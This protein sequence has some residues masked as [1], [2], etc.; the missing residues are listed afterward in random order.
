VRYG[1]SLLPI[2][3][4]LDELRGLLNAR[5]RGDD[6]FSRGAALVKAYLGYQ[7][8]RDEWVREG[9]DRI[10]EID[11]ERDREAAT[12]PTVLRAAWLD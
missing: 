8:Q 12:L 10:E 7:V 3:Q 5:L 11:A 6:E 2:G 9:L 1:E 4:R